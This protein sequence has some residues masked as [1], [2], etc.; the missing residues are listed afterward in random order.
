[1]T[2]RWD[3]AGF[4]AVLTALALALAPSLANASGLPDPVRA[5]LRGRPIPL[6][7][8]A[9]Y[10]C[11]DGAYP[12]IRCFATGA[13]RDHDIGADPGNDGSTGWP[14]TGLLA[15]AGSLI[16]FYY[17]TFYQDESY[18][19]SSFTASQSIANLGDYGW[20]DAITSFRSLNGQRPKWWENV[21]YV[22]PSWQWPAGAWVPNVGQGANDTFSSVKNVP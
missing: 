16:S 17:V 21:N 7:Q 2:Q 22:T 18:G 20:N 10:H 3:G 1:M 12:V 15:P 13:E 6:S 8:V 5:E 14:A 9:Q 4:A 19:G 11:H